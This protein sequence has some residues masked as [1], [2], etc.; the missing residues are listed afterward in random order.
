[1][2]KIKFHS[3]A[4]IEVTTDKSSLLVDPWLV[5]SCYWRSWW[6]YPPL[7]DIDFDKLNPRVIY[8]THVHWDHWHGPTLK[9]FLTKNVLIVTHD[10][11]NKRSR[12]DLENFGFTN[13][14]VLKHNETFEFGDIKITSYQFG[15][16]LNDSAI[17]IET[18]KIK[19]LNAN[20]CKIAGQSLSQIKKNHGNFDFALR[21]H[22]SA[23][24]RICYQIKGSNKTFDDPGHYS[25]S[26]KLFM[27]NVKPKYAVPFASN[28]CHLHKDVFSFNNVI[29]DPYN[30]EKDIIL[31]GG[32]KDSELKIMLSGDSFD[33]VNG[34]KVNSN[35]KKYFEF[36]ED[37]L[38]EYAE[39]NKIILDNYYKKEA[40]QRLNKR[41]IKKF[42]IQLNSIP[43]F[44]KRKLKNWKFIILL[45]KG[46]KF[47]YLEVSP[48]T[49]SVK[50]VSEHDIP[51]Y[52]TK[53][54]IPLIIF[55]DAV[56]S[57]MFH[58]AGISKRNKYVF[59]NELELT[60]WGI[61][62]KNLERVELE[63]FPLSFSYVF[64]FFKSYFRRWREII[65]YF[66]TLF[67]LRKGMEIYD[68]EEKILK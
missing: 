53:I 56:N 67:Y 1:M 42:E 58:H 9:K 66:R 10:E 13:I 15:L 5:G 18:K 2:E 65:V 32:L 39:K 40:R 47:E 33:T 36:K 48:Y 27:D 22:S 20:D 3:H 11:P 46:E 49:S 34:F 6:N 54:Y 16:F 52:N 51:N 12:R 63:V 31:D 68:V 50:L 4:C 59:N 38:I 62:N 64:N 7:E 21:S 23:N 17:V 57:N 19:I 44:F 25:R 8:I 35:N 37:Y 26:F 29:N 30:L 55:N 61:L 60:K 14:K 24:D 43:L 41:T 28:H 45:N